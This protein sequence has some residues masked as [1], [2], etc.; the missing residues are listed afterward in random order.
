MKRT[1]KKLII[2]VLTFCVAFGGLPAAMNSD[3][4]YASSKS[5]KKIVLKAASAGKTTVK[6]KWNKVKSPGKGYAVFRDGKVIK[7]LSTKKTSFT[8][9]GL[10]PGTKHRYQIK[11]Y[12]KKKVTKWYNKKTGKWQKKKPAKKYCGKS[13][14]VTTYVYRNKS[15]I[16][17]VR[18]KSSS[19][20]SQPSDQD[21]S[22][23]D[24]NKTTDD[25]G[26][27]DTSV[28][29][30]TD[31]SDN[32]KP[33]SDDTDTSNTDKTGS[34]DTATSA[35]D[36]SAP[37]GFS[38]KINS[39][40]YPEFKWNSVSGATGYRLYRTYNGSTVETSVTTTTATDTTVTQG[41]IYEY[42]VIALK[43]STTSPRSETISVP[44]PLRTTVANYSGETT[45]IY[46]RPTENV[47][48]Y[49]SNNIKVGNMAEIDK[50][51]DGEFESIDGHMIQ[52]HGAT[53]NA[54]KIEN[55]LPKNYDYSV[56]MHN[57]DSSKFTIE[58]ESGMDIKPIS[59]YKEV[60][61]HKYEQTAKYYYF[62][63]GHPIAQPR[64]TDGA[65]IYKTETSDSI[66]TKHFLVINSAMA[67]GD[68]LGI[69]AETFNVY[70]KYDGKLIGTITID[71]ARDEFLGSS[72]TSQTASGMS[73]WRRVA[74]NIAEQAIA[75]KGGTTGSI[76]RD[77]RLIEDYLEENYVYG[78]DVEVYGA[79]MPM[80]CVAGAII[81]ETYSIVHYNKFGFESSGSNY[82]S[83][84]HSAFNLNEDPQT[85][86]ETQGRLN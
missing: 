52:Y 15:N 6:L 18:T 4:A 19:K 86:Y 82:S 40:G 60:G 81:L 54:T 76:N 38:Y 72:W 79:T 5:P 32:G 74:L 66:T 57:G 70:V 50:T 58:L 35:T 44:V 20:E 26:D 1:L 27:T 77:L 17:R 85:Y 59:T 61:N 67:V 30:D 25:T 53:F 31:N 80:K 10:K 84:T 48:R 39:D 71:T 68:A 22:N 75:A 13:K 62:K 83:G 7:R 78:E 28:T 56:Q 12:T 69:W 55:A 3:E 9:K 63:N 37:T 46:K 64:V 23:I 42:Y 73:P 33:A 14:K 65:F 36:I 24:V 45:T 2:F 34:D 11:T 41:L 49:A 51:V 47:W 16:L 29:N 8:D 21:D 43:G